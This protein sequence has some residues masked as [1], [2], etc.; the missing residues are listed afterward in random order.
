MKPS[1]E[2]SIFYDGACHLCSREIDHYRKI[3]AKGKIRFV[4]IADRSFD[5]ESEGLKNPKL[6]QK[7]LHVKYTNGKIVTGVEAF[8]SIWETLGRFKFLTTLAKTPVS[9]HFMK[10][11][12][13]IFAQIRPYLPK[14]RNCDT[15]TCQI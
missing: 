1:H 12:Y 2:I 9:G 14:K 15:G 10:L 11:G 4:N 5:I 3:D 6:V 13:Q 8:V 7:Y